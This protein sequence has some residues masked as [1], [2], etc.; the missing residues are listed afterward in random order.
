MPAKDN[1]VKKETILHGEAFDYYY[2]LG[3]ERTH[4]KV[5]EVF[6]LS[7]KKVVDNWSRSFNWQKRIEERDAKN[8][9]RMQAKTD[10][11]LVNTKRKYREEINLALQPIKAAINSSFEKDKKTGKMNI[12]PRIQTPRDLQ[13]V[14]A[15]YE[16]LVKL[17]LL[18]M[19]EDVDKGHDASI[20]IH[21]DV[22]SDDDRKDY[23]DA[24]YRIRAISGKMELTENAAT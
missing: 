13:S 10:T 2:S 18:L 16:K 9:A 11:E 5:A 6:G 24:A 15:A 3:D 7:S 12:I 23:F 4:K 21:L 8:N 19:G 22:M 20:N 1:L 14:V 17:D